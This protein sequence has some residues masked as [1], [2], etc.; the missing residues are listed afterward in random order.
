VEIVTST[1]PFKSIGAHRDAAY[2]ETGPSWV[3]G[4]TYNPAKR[5][6]QV[7][8]NEVYILRPKAALNQ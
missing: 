7:N 8:G 2:E 6:F 5:N 3:E 1:E 4:G